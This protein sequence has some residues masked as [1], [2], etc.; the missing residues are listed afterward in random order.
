MSELQ[1]AFTTFL[2]MTHNYITPHCGMYR[3]FHFVWMALLEVKV[4]KTAKVTI[5]CYEHLVVK[6][7]FLHQTQEVLYILPVPCTN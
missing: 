7:N 2:H 3:K 6:S 4:H 1:S 5:L